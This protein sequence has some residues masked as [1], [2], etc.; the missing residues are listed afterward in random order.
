LFALIKFPEDIQAKIKDLPYKEQVETAY[1]LAFEDSSYGVGKI[2]KL[3]LLKQKSYYSSYT[4]GDE[5]DF[6]EDDKNFEEY[7]KSK[8]FPFKFKMLFVI[9]GDINFDD[10]HVRV[11]SE[12]AE[13]KR[14]ISL[15]D[16]IKEFN[17]EELL[18]G[19]NQVYC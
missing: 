8:A 3:K 5:M 14:I 1:K 6:L 18:V 13:E 19:N 9:D 15:D 2:Y 17:S 7:V 10:L 16:C 4:S 11:K 12:A